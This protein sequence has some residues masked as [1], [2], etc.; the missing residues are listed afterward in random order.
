VAVLKDVHCRS[1]GNVSD[2]MMDQDQTFVLKRCVRCRQTGKHE[3]CCTGG[4]KLKCYAGS[5]DGR[6]WSGDVKHMGV[7][8][9]DAD[10]N[11]L[12]EKDGTPTHKKYCADQDAR[13]AAN[14]D[15]KRFELGQK[16]GTN[17]L[18]FDQRATSA[19]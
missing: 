19:R 1:C 16:R 3:S 11:A 14:R 13:I 10:G 7:E 2:S 6:D 12:L 4:V 8:A 5:Y 17:S 9:V 18:R 15:R